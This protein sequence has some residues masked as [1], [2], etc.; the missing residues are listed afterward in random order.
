MR[1]RSIAI[2]ASAVACVALLVAGA[3]VRQHR[4]PPGLMRDVRAGLVARSIEDPDARLRAY[5]DARYGSMVDAANREAA[6]LDFF[7]LDHIRALQFLVKHSPESH[8]QGN[9]DA[10]GRWVAGYRASLT[11]EQR[12]ALN[13]QF[14]TPEG[15]Q[16]L[17][18]ATAQC[19]MLRTFSIA[20]ARPVSSPNC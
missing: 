3:W 15:Q 11:P 5:L 1:K 10:M 8:R 18:R 16:M 12:A 13:A 17:K 2:F 19:R 20:A 9:V 14:Q 4:I 7:N 6:F